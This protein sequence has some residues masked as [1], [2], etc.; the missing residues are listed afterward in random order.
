M[1]TVKE[2]IDA[3]LAQASLDDNISFAVKDKN[4]Y[5]L[6]TPA[7]EKTYNVDEEVII[8]IE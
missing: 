6:K 3:V 2:F 4:C 8:V 1:I 5:I 7:L